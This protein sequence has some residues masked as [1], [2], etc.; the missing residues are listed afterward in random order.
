M[1]NYSEGMPERDPGFLGDRPRRPTGDTTAEQS[2]PSGESTF[3]CSICL[4]P[5]TEPVVSPCGHLFC[6]Q[7]LYRWMET[8]PN[9]VPCPVCKAGISSFIRLYGMKDT[10]AERLRGKEEAEEAKLRDAVED[11]F[12]QYDDRISRLVGNRL[13]SQQDL[14]DANEKMQED[15]FRI[16]SRE[17]WQFQQLLEKFKEELKNRIQ[18]RYEFYAKKRDEREREAEKELSYVMT[19]AAWDYDTRMSRL[20]ESASISEQE[21]RQGHAEYCR[22][23]IAALL[24]TG[25]QC[26]HLSTKFKDEL[27]KLLDDK[28]EARMKETRELRSTVDIAF[29]QYV[30]EMSRLTGAYL[31]SERNLIEADKKLRKE[32]LEVVANTE[33]QYPSLLKTYQDQL[34]KLIDEEYDKQ[35][36]ARDAKAK[37]VEMEL[38]EAVQLYDGRMNRF[39]EGPSPKEKKELW[40][41][42]LEYSQHALGTLSEGRIRDPHVIKRHFNAL[43]EVLAQKHAESE[44]RRRAAEERAEF[45][46]EKA[47]W[48]AAE[49]YKRRRN[50]FYGEVV[51]KG[52]TLMEIHEKQMEATLKRFRNNS[53]SVAEWLVKEYEEVL[54]EVLAQKHAESEERRRAAEER[55]EFQMEKAC[56]SAAEEYK[57]RRNEFY[58]EVVVKGGT[59]VENHEKQMEAA[60]KRFRNNSGSVAEW[61]VKEYEEVLVEVSL[62][63]PSFCETVRC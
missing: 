52:G 19:S 55:A 58:G 46:M 62:P 32:A 9:L 30:V 43:I 15:A 6:R 11:A 4:E 53:R 38:I 56:W 34:E 20:C 51:V 17:R 33:S 50:E 39:L 23:A 37:E 42:H 60:L 49:E 16:L 7:C 40:T 14:L 21:L 12:R 24:E 28:C 18:T 48:S 25:S 2:N 1:A 63:D 44:E 27:E 22:L 54:V 8:S 35:R 41:R 10:S 26:P 61:L 36:R 29:R 57:R 45:Q 5:P 31:I 47:C 13:I 59:L 3:E